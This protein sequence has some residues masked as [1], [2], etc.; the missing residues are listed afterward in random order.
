MGRQLTYNDADIEW[1]D[2]KVVWWFPRQWACNSKRL[3]TLQSITQN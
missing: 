2:M 1:W 3:M